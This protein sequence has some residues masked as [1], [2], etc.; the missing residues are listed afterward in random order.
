MSLGV[1]LKALRIEQGLSQTDVAKELSVSRG[2]VSMLENNKHVPGTDIIIKA[3]KLFG[4]P[5]EYFH[6]DNILT[7]EEEEFLIDLGKG[8]KISEKDGIYRV[9]VGDK[10]ASEED[11]EAFINFM[12]FR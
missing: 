3:A 12:K 10:V 7:R 1:K 11:L 5:V 2:Y 6:S 4:V 9:L 8:L